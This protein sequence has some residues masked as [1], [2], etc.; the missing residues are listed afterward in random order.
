MTQGSRMYRY[1]H[2]QNET[3]VGAEISDI[4]DAK[5]DKQSQCRQSINTA[6]LQSRFKDAC[7]E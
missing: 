4:Q 1:S 5:T 3:P 2:A 7:H 6:Q